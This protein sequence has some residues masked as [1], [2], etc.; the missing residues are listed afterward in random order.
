MPFPSPPLLAAAETTPQEWLLAF[1]ALASFVMLGIW[2]IARQRIRAGVVQE[3]RSEL[4]GRILA[5]F[6]TGMEARIGTERSPAEV[7]VAGDDPADDA[8]GGILSYANIAEALSGGYAGIFYI[9]VRTGAFEPFRS[10]GHNVA[11]AEYAGRDYFSP[12]VQRAL[13][14]PVHPDDVPALREAFRRERLLAETA[15]SRSPT[16]TRAAPAASRSGSSPAPRAS[17]ATTAPS[18]S[19]SPSPTSTS[20]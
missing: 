6:R 18:A 14:A 15:S 5:R 13:L 4:I 3:T 17:P 16:A 11:L 9:D 10:D 8:L 1:F 7:S 19:S 2:A 12:E 20:R